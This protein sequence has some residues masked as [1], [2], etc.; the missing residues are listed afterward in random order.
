MYFYTSENGQISK[1][2][3]SHQVTLV[4]IE[5]FRR[6]HTQRA[7]TKEAI[8]IKSLLILNYPVG[9]CCKNW[10]FINALDF[11]H[12]NKLLCWEINVLET[13]SAKLI[14]VNYS[15]IISHFCCGRR[16]HHLIGSF[17]FFSLSIIKKEWV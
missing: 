17:L 15:Q 2:Q 16:P 12:Q 6:T 9:F 1:T 11:S 8:R 10:L 4:V 5:V 13:R 14:S 7:C 3:Y